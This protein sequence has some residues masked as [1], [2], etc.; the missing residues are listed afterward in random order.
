MRHLSS[1]VIAWGSNFT[2]FLSSRTLYT[3]GLFKAVRNFR[4]MN[5]RFFFQCLSR[6]T[7]SYSHPSEHVQDDAYH[8][9]LFNYGTML[10]AREHVNFLLRRFP[11]LRL[12]FS[13]FLNIFT[14]LRLIVHGSFFFQ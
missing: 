5:V 1:A 2:K 8:V 11:C 4:P 9:H 14:E 7:L 13:V 10:F 12:Q 6:K 3:V